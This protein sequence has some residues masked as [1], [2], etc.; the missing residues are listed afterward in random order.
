MP[1]N[2]GVESVLVL[3]TLTGCQ[4]GDTPE[5][6]AMIREA[7]LQMIYAAVS[8]ITESAVDVGSIDVACGPDFNYG[9]FVVDVGP[10]SSP[11]IVTVPPNLLCPTVVSKTNW[12]GG[13]FNDKFNVDVNRTVMTVN[14]ID[15]D[16]PWGVHLK[17]KCFVVDEAQLVEGE[18]ED[19]AK[20]EAPAAIGR[21]VRIDQLHRFHNRQI[22]YSRNPSV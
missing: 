2:V 11:T 18:D 4:D 13:G 19:D 5:T 1:K 15:T 3:Q 8:S 22:A 17:F 7:H 14:R 12:I 16:A 9:S 10:G 6:Q 21:Y 20:K